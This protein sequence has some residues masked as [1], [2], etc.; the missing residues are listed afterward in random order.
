MLV[1]LPLQYKKILKFENV[2]AVVSYR[3][4]REIKTVIPLSTKRYHRKL[5]VGPLE[6]IPRT[7]K[8]T[9]HCELVYMDAPQVFNVNNFNKLSRGFFRV[10]YNFFKNVHNSYSKKNTNLI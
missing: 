4:S 6:S 8:A 10:I 9:P 2:S 5:S 1:V 7:G 3:S